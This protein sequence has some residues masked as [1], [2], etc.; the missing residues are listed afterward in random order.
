M[1]TNKNNQTPSRIV[2]KIDRKVSLLTYNT[3]GIQHIF[4]NDQP[5]LVGDKNSKG[6]RLKEK[7]FGDNQ[8]K[9]GDI[10]TIKPQWQDEGDEDITFTCLEDEDGGRIRIV[11]DIDLH[12]NPQSI[13]TTDMISHI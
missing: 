7:F 8:F 6:F 2:S 10:V 3:N 12:C 9:K 5:Y 4:V 11:Y 13:V 1:T